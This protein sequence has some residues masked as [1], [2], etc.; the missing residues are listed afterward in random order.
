MYPQL[1]KHLYHTVKTKHQLR[2]CQKLASSLRQPWS[3]NC[4]K[5][6]IPEYLNK[7]TSKE[8]KWRGWS[9]E[10]GAQ[11]RR[12]RHKLLLSRRCKSWDGLCAK[13]P[14]TSPSLSRRQ[15]TGGR[16]SLKKHLQ[17]QRLEEVFASHRQTSIGET[18][19]KNWRGNSRKVELDGEEL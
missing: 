5:S 2:E 12:V 16:T 17:R 9:R 1:H 10:T 15:T 14:P 8:P 19:L 3:L 11:E 13:F 4:H 18:T 7:L 6:P